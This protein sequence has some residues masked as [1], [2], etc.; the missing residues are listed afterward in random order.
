MRKIELETGDVKSGQRVK[1]LLEK[2]EEKINVNG[3]LIPTNQWE[4]LL[5]Q[6]KNPGPKQGLWESLFSS[7]HKLEGIKTHP[8]PPLADLKPVTNAIDSTPKYQLFLAAIDLTDQFLFEKNNRKYQ[9]L[10][11]VFNGKINSRHGGNGIFMIDDDWLGNDTDTELSLRIDELIDKNRLCK[12]VFDGNI[13][14]HY[15]P[16]TI[17]FKP[18]LSKKATKSWNIVRNYYHQ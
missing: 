14:R 5:D 2:E 11:L 9:A 7:R 15:V 17:P 6:L 16:Y 3:S 1:F 10:C 4:L 8:V 12:I 13:I 18:E